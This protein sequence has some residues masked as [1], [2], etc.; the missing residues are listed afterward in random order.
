MARALRLTYAGAFYHVTCQGN[1]RQPIFR[2]D[3]D[4]LACMTGW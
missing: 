2:D 3:R 4:R 1:A